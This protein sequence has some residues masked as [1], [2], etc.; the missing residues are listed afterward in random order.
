MK[1]LLK[2]IMANT[3]ILTPAQVAAVDALML[4]EGFEFQSLFRD[5]SVELTRE[6]DGSTIVR[7]VTRSG[8]ICSI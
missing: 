8:D 1:S 5:G 6:V 3:T 4:R 7:Y 2:R